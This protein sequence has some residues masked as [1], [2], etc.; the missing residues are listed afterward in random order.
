MTRCGPVFGCDGEAS[1]TSSN[2]HDRSRHSSCDRSYGSAVWER[3]ERIN[4]NEEG[5]GLLRQK[6][7]VVMN[8]MV[9][10]VLHGLNSLEAAFKYS[11]KQPQRHEVPKDVR[12]N[13]CCIRYLR[14]RTHIAPGQLGY[15]DQKWHTY[16]LSGHSV[17]CIEVD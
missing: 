1:I 9:V 4:D 13:R 11:R 7:Y 15:V 5:Q 2:H 14:E 3:K 12:E 17:T 8:V 10:M 16:H 6:H